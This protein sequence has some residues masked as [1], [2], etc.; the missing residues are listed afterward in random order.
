VGY[1]SGD[2]ASLVEKHPFTMRMDEIEELRL[3]QAGAA[4]IEIARKGTGFHQ[5]APSDRD[6]EEAEADAATQ[7]LERIAISEAR[8]VSR[9]GAGA[10]PFA[11]VGRA[12]VR[13]GEREQVVEIG[14]AGP[15]G[16]ATLRRLLDDARLDIDAILLRRL[17]PA[18]PDSR[19]A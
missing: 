4:T 11:S 6:L 13:S 17:T 18:P 19:A 12:V 2:A 1:L 15:D 5:R 3:E 7:L 8:A 14:A 10:A 9:G 16:R